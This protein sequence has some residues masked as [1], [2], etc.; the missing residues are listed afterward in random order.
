MKPITKYSTSTGSRSN[1]PT[2]VLFLSV[3]LLT[4]LLNAQTLKNTEIKSDP[5][6]VG[7]SSIQKVVPGVYFHEGQPNKGYCNNG[8]VVFDDYVLVIDANYPSGAKVV[9]PL[10]KVT[11]DKPVRFVFDTH[12]HPDHVY[13]NVV[14]AD[15]GA[16]IIATTRALEE[17]KKAE[18]GYFGSKPGGWEA[19]AIDR[20]DVAT[21]HFKPPTLLFPDELIFDDGHQ[22]VELHWYGPG[23]TPGDGYVWFP[24]Q[25]I[26]FTGDACVNGPRNKVEDGNISDWIKTLEIVKNLDAKIVCPGHGPMGG[27]EIIVDQQAYF[28]ELQKQVKALVDDGKTAVEIKASV[29]TIAVNLKKI[30]NIAR[31]VQTNETRHVQKVYLELGGTLFP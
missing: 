12:H 5:H 30:P 16:T 14:W 7:A 2:L 24:K 19:K 15:A 23:H 25:K 3:S 11:T 6:Y 18:T 10:I 27:P 31:Y 9:M 1:L 22:R 20:P 28:I 8:W 13:G 4:G 26:L 29:P 17:M 21:T